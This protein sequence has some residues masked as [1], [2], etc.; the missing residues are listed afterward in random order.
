MKRYIQIEE[1]LKQIKEDSSLS[2]DARLSTLIHIADEIIDI[3]DEQASEPGHDILSAELVK[4]FQQKV[5]VF[6]PAK[7]EQHFNDLLKKF[8]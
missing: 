1:N 6:D 8:K 4:A 3:V 2:T 5:S 7:N